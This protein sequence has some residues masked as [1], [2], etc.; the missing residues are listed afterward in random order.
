LIMLKTIKIYKK[1][2]TRAIDK[3]HKKPW[4][5][6]RFDVCKFKNLENSTFFW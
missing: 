3:I 1:P 2:D 5:I 6:A 4:K